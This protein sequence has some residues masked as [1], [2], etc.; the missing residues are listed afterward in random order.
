MEGREASPSYVRQ[1]TDGAEMQLCKEIGDDRFTLMRLATFG[2]PVNGSF[3]HQDSFDSNDDELLEDGKGTVDIKESS[4][5][6]RR[7]VRMQ[8]LKVSY[9]TE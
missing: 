5:K 2:Y 6:K 7:N 8:S 1:N 9:I 4:Y 3:I